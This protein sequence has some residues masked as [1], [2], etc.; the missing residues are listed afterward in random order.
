[1]WAQLEDPESDLA[2]AWDREHDEFVARRLLFLMETEFSPVTWAAF[3]LQVIDS[4]P[5]AQVASELGL[6]INAVRIAKYRVLA[7]LRKE[8]R[9]LID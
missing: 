3:R 2:E 5:P 7:R 4:R 8:G 1:M 6:T 9:G